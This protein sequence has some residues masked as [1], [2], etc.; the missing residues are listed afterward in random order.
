MY[1][2]LSHY[3]AL[4]FSNSFK[5]MCVNHLHTPKFFI[6]AGLR[7]ERRGNHDYEMS[8]VT[9]KPVFRVFYQVILKQVCSATEIS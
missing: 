1:M 2:F 3:K 9:R 6:F 8:L 7:T 4:I 5:M